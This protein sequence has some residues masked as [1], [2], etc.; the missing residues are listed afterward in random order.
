M[1]GLVAASN[2]GRSCRPQLQLG[3]LA[4]RGMA[5][6]GG[7]L[8]MLLLLALPLLRTRGPHTAQVRRYGHVLWSV[9]YIS[10]CVP[11][12]KAAGFTVL[13]FATD[14]A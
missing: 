5:A 14:S 8:G 11:H 3:L 9:M 2:P 6:S 1:D 12:G 4:M 10:I 13:R 7:M